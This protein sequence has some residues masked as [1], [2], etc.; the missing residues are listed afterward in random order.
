MAE[1]DRKQ[2]AQDANQNKGP[3]PPTKF[4]NDTA[5]KDYETGR[6]QGKK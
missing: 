1:S 4:T 3:K 6:K 2:G 5:R